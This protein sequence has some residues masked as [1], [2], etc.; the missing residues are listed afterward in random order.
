MN[1]TEFRSLQSEYIDGTLDDATAEKMQA[2][3]EECS[4]CRHIHGEL[5]ALVRTLHDMDDIPVPSTLADKVIA[6]LPAQK[7]KVISLPRML[8]SWQTY[9]VAAAFILVVV[10]LYSGTFNRYPVTDGASVTYTVSPPAE[11]AAFAP[12]PAVSAEAV[13]PVPA[14]VPSTAPRMAQTP[15]STPQEDVQ[16]TEEALALSPSVSRSFPAP[17]E[18]AEVVYNGAA[19]PMDLSADTAAPSKVSLLKKR[20]VFTTANPS[21]EA[22]Y[23]AHEAE[24]ALA[25]EAA[26]HAAGIVFTIEEQIEVDYTEE[27]T[28]LLTEADGL[29]EDDVRLPGIE[30]EM[31]ILQDACK[32]PSLSLSIQP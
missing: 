18:E 4:S 6:N 12:V 32:V 2:H 20:L 28:A 13:S 26:F 3:M 8:R 1:C 27:Y 5:S 24:G 21:A 17:Q 30:K 16:I 15:V 10:T 23:S 29:S 31:R 14:V 25:V 9:S 11:D 7:K 19:V 22:I